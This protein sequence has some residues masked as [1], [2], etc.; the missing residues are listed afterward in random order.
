MSSLTLWISG[1]GLIA[2]LYI[3]SPFLS[4]SGINKSLPDQLSDMEQQKELIF[5]QLS[6]LEYDYHMDKITERDYQKAKEEL[7]AE[8]AA[9]IEKD[10]MD[11]QSIEKKVDEEI[12]RYLQSLKTT[13]EQEARHEG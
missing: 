7:M 5:N 6:D 8:A 13:P 11:T 10:Q 1:L 3:F 12:D 2:I 9:I 4:K